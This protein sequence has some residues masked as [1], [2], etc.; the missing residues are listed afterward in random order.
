MH[1]ETL[2]MTEYE[3]IDQFMTR[4]MGIINQ[5]R[6]SGQDIPDQR[7]VEKVL[8]SI[9]NKFEMVVTSILESN[10]LLKFQ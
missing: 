8:K 9:P 7:I 1:F 2:K 10:D 5:I 3:N 6:L 4:V